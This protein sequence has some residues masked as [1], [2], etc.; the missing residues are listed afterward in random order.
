MKKAITIILCIVM[1]VSVCPTA[2]AAG[3]GT[4]YYVDSINGDDTNSGKSVSS[5]WKTLEKGQIFDF[6]GKNCLF[7]K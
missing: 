7:L 4:T 1:L 5:A 3:D 6:L 2:F